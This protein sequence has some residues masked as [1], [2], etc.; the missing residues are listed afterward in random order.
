MKGLTLLLVLVLVTLAI[1]QF[2]PVNANVYPATTAP[3]PAGVQITF[4][5]QSPVENAT[6]SNG[7]IDAIFNATIDGPSFINGQVINKV[8]TYTTYKGDWMQEIK[9]CRPSSIFYTLPFYGFNFSITGIPFG[10]HTVNFTG[11]AQGDFVL[12]N[13][14]FRVYVLEKTVSLTF[15]VLANPVIEFSSPQNANS[16]TSS[17]PLNFTVDHAVTEITYI[18]DGQ[19]STPISGNTTLTDLPNGRHN[20]TVYATDEFGYTGASNTLF[21]N[22]NSPESF[23]VIPVI[24]VSAVAVAVVA[25]LLVYLKKRQRSNSA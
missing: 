13:G 20:V 9:W 18:L 2:L 6:Y 15:F 4:D 19:E 7:A 1:S 25:G 11:H 21:F 3:A 23:P 8:L 22:V 16:T 24:A 14:S 17:F 12:A 10:Q 5:M